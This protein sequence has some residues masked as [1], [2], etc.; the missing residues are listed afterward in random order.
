M[1]K[2]KTF[3][4]LSWSLINTIPI[5]F[6]D[7]NESRKKL[8]VALGE[9]L[10]IQYFACLRQWFLFHSTMTKDAFDEKV[11]HL[12]HTNEQI[13]CHNNFLL[14][15]LNKASVRQVNNKGVFEAADYV[16]KSNKNY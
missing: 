9:N 8:E 4:F 15:I 16:G 6:L 12:F 5:I 1:G 13:E 2:F 3:F 10:R 11:R 14:A 7:L